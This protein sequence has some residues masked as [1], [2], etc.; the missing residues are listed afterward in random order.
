MSFA[1]RPLENEPAA[2][3]TPPCPLCGGDGY[4]SELEGCHDLKLG[5]PGTFTVDRCRRCGL[6]AT[7][8][9]PTPERI[10]DWYPAAYADAAYSPAHGPLARAILAVLATPFRLLRRSPERVPDAVPGARL[11]DVGC[12]NGSYL[13][14]MAARGWEV[15]GIEPTETPIVDRR[16]EPRIRR[17]GLEDAEMPAAS[18]DLVT[19]WHV[20]EHL[21]EPRRA[22][23]RIRPWLRSDGRLR[24]AVPNAACFD[25]RV[26]RS[27][28][29]GLD[30]PRHLYHFTPRTLR[31]LLEESGYAVERVLPEYETTS[32][33]AS[34]VLLAAPRPRPARR[35]ATVAVQVPLLPVSALRAV[36]GATGAIEA[37]ARPLP[38]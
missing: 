22:L 19:L 4:E 21:H 31:A 29:F 20:L 27:R 38:L 8:P 25:A 35:I 17:S 10:G 23:E 33:P 30:V 7:R 13:Q 1:A 36:F 12:G 15:V 11:L 32:L 24:I 28:W 34:I 14:A 16:L 3:G 26:F 5:L 6:L 9:Q 37:V 2:V 18:F